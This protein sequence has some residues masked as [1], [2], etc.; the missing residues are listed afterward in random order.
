ML[1]LVLCLREWRRQ[2]VIAGFVAA[3]AVPVLLL[4]NFGRFR[5]G[6]A[7]LWILLAAFGL[8]WLVRLWRTAAERRALR[9]TGSLALIAAVTALAFLPPL[10]YAQMDY[11]LGSLLLTGTLR[12][13][14]D[15]PRGAELS[16]QEALQQARQRVAQSAGADHHAT[17]KMAEA[18]LELASLYRSQGRASE[19][20]EHFG[21]AIDAQPGSLEAHFNLANLL[22]ESGRPEAA[23]E[24]Y[25]RALAIAPRDVDTLINL[26][27]A[28]LSQGELEAA[29]QHFQAALVIE[30][31]N[32][33][34]HYNLANASLMQGQIDR[35]IQHYLQSLA[36]DSNNA[37]A[38]NNLG[39]AYLLQG[40]PNHANAQRNLA[41]VLEAQRESKD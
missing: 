19:A 38:H 9:L 12:K 37:D 39:Q 13:R 11:R 32:A 21:R 10:G 26:G 15:D 16:F 30:P 24:H 22:M 6:L 20:L 4:Y 34:A 31:R 40:D 14:A 27:H 1:G 2:W 8:D 23:I 41:R 28:R 17:R 5:I 25:Q 3:Y 36:A 35:A 7:P 29:A 33:R 18:H